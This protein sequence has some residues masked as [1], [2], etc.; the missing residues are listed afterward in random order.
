MNNKFLISIIIP[1]YNCEK[2]L[3]KCIESVLGQSYRNIEVILVNDGSYDN[4]QKIC[5][6]YADKDKRVKVIHKKN[7]GPGAARRDGISVS[8]GDYI[9]FVDADDYIDK[10]MYQFLINKAENNNI[11]IIQCGYREVN[12]NGETIKTYYLDN[13]YIT[14]KYECS[15]NYA[16]Q[17]NT[18][19]YL[20]NKLFRAHLFKNVVYPELYAGEDSCLLTQLYSFSEK[21]I[22][23]KECFY[24]YVMTPES[25]CRMPFSV[26]RL[27]NIEAGKFMYHFYQSCFPEL[28]KF[29]ALHIC[30]YA[31]QC[32]CELS[33]V[34]IENKKEILESLIADSNEFYKLI[35][36]NGGI[37]KNLK[38]RIL[39]IKLFRFNRKL[40]S[41]VFDTNNYWKSKVNN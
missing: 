31:A 1:V 3:K 37:I 11:D 19:N 29:A 25:L 40:C 21:V 14:G 15:Y 4:S 35:R 39:F 24:N 12:I 23:V 34:N 20:W 9:T 17:S 2:F 8:S 7:A 5:D 10:N 22:T 16:S 36:N 13:D 18:T 33:K 38:T 26:K 28:S 30:S 32:Y 41:L 27:D 6:S